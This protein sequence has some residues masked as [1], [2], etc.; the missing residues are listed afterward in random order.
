VTNAIISPIL[1]GEKLETPPD[2]ESHSILRERFEQALK[3]EHRHFGEKIKESRSPMFEFVRAIKNCEGLRYLDE[4]EAGQIINGLMEARHPDSSD[5]WKSEFPEHECPLEA[6]LN[7][8]TEVRFPSGQLK[9]AAILAKTK[10]IQPPGLATKGYCDLLALA[11]TLQEL[12]GDTT[13]FLATRQVGEALGVSKSTVATYICLAMK[14]GFLQRTQEGVFNLG[15]KVESRAAEYRFVDITRPLTNVQSVEPGHKELKG[16]QGIQGN[17]G[18][19]ELAILTNRNYE[20]LLVKPGKEE[21]AKEEKESLKEVCEDTPQVQPDG[22]PSMKRVSKTQ[23]QA[24]IHAPAPSGE[25][26]QWKAYL[27]SNGVQREPTGKELGSLKKFSNDF[28][29]RAASILKFVL[30]HWHEFA[31]HGGPSCPHIGWLITHEV[32]AVQAYEKHL[33]AIADKQA[34]EAKRAAMVAAPAPPCSIFQETP[35]TVAEMLVIDARRD[36]EGNSPSQAQLD[37]FI[38][39]H[40]TVLWGDKEG[41]YAIAADLEA[42]WTSV[43]QPTDAQVKPSAH[44]C[45]GSE[46]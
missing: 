5:A 31:G 33:A 16:S 34:W 10:C 22:L 36:R 26:S 7:N 42:L 12:S 21:T 3:I 28:G 30:S 18:L 29:D 27:A 45:I 38:L 17:Q 39:K 46:T 9:K 8:W 11:A 24:P 1:P 35:M 23:W 15:K 41:Y 37:A 2:P 13:I 6:F 43:D 32:E 25:V 14:A 4:Q 19:Q 20:K 44:S 40:N